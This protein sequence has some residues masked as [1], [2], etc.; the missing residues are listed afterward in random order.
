LVYGGDN[1]TRLVVDGCRQATQG[2]L[3]LDQTVQG[4]EGERGAV[5]ARVDRRDQVARRVEQVKISL[6]AI[7][8]SVSH[9]HELTGG[10]Q[11]RAVGIP[12]RALNPQLLAGAALVGCGFSAGGGFS[13]TKGSPAIGP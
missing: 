8:I 4:V 6:R 5:A 12:Q 3:H 13:R 7:G 1:I 11:R 9:G 2:V 10:I